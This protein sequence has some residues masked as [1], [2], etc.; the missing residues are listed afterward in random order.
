MTTYASEL[1][2]RWCEDVHRRYGTT[3]YFATRMFPKAL[4]RR[5]HAVYAFVRVPDEWVDN[6][7]GL[8]KV[9]VAERLQDWRRQLVAG[10]QQSE[11]PEH[12]AM[13]AFC[14][15][16]RETAM[17]LEEPSRFIEAMEMDLTV[18]RYPT[19]ADL[20]RYMAGS[21]AAVGL[22]MCHVVGGPMDSHSLRAARTLGE[23]M[24]MTNFIR[25][26]AEDARRGRIYLPLEDLDRFG[27]KEDDIFEG[28][29]TPEVR[30]LVRFEIE[31]TRELY[32]ASDPGIRTLQGSTRRA[33]SLARSLYS[34]ILDRVEDQDCNVFVGR[35]RTTPIEKGLVALRVL[36][37]P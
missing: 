16:V 37:F 13:R 23:A 26:V 14:D 4:R 19:Y 27:V 29:F 11:C 5:V 15:V 3:Y 17:P 34:R 22:M 21:A 31:R 30:A 12:P 24:Q 18:N 35:A 28:R 1:D 8:S 25:D 20:Q 7:T 9:E 36:V 10:T 33:V 2:H 6:P 32:R